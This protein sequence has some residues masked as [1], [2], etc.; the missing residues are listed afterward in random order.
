MVWQLLHRSVI[1]D[2]CRFLSDEHFSIQGADIPGFESHRLGRLQRNVSRTYLQ[3]PAW[4]SERGPC[5]Q[6]IWLVKRR[7][8]EALVLILKTGLLCCTS[9]AHLLVLLGMDGRKI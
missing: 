9:M 8:I 2:T 5:Y 1:G 4:A 7:R 3:S 6:Q